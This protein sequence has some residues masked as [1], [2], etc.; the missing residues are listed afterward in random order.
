MFR[1][2]GS[3]PSASNRACPRRDCHAAR[4]DLKRTVLWSPT[5]GDAPFEA[6]VRAAAEHGYRFLE[7]TAV[8]AQAAADRG[9]QPIQMKSWASDLGVEIPMFDGFS[10]WYPHPTPKRSAMP[11]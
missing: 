1:Y 8:D 4:M 5:L 9:Q 3:E 7:V 2:P 6:R 11:A 10:D